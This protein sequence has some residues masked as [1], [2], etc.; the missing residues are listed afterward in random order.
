LCTKLKI[1]AKKKFE[2]LFKNNP[3]RVTII[4]KQIPI[5]ASP[6]SFTKREANKKENRVIATVPTTSFKL[7]KFHSFSLLIFKCSLG[8]P[9]SVATA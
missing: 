8:F 9:L 2:V 4:K 6:R 1:K 5:E 7:I 3:E